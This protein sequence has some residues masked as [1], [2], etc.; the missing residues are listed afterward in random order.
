MSEAQSLWGWF[1]PPCFNSEG[2]L[3][4][5][6]RYNLLCRTMYLYL[7]KINTL[8]LFYLYYVKYY[9]FYNLLC[10]TSSSVWLEIWVAYLMSDKTQRPR[11]IAVGKGVSEKK[12]TEAEDVVWA[13]CGL[14]GKNGRKSQAIKI[15][16]FFGHYLHSCIT[17]AIS[18]KRSHY[19]PYSWLKILATE[20]KLLQHN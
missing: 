8:Y 10:R 5:Q 16:A 11:T 17:T 7:C 14:K 19:L 6:Q 9:V 13:C 2:L 1:L 18:R 12:W 3:Y 20:D 4:I 15:S